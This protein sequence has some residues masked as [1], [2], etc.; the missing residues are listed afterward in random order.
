MSF[1][2]YPHQSGKY[3]TDFI[4][5]NNVVSWDSR[6]FNSCSNN[7]VFISAPTGMGKTYF[8]E[9]TLVRCLMRKNN[10]IN[11]KTKILWIGNRVA[12]TRQGKQRLAEKLCDI[13]G[14]SDFIHK[15][16][17][18]NE[19][20]LDSFH[21]FG[22]V[23]IYSYQ[24]LTHAFTFDKES[25]RKLFQENEFSYIVFDECHYFTS[26]ALF[27]TATDLL[28]LE[29][30]KL[31][32]RSLRIYMSA[33]LEE[34]YNVISSAEFNVMRSLN[35]RIPEEEYYYY[36][37]RNYNHIKNIFAYDNLERL[38]PK[39]KATPKDK[40]LIFV[41]SK[42]DGKN[43]KENL[44]GYSKKDSTKKTSD[45]TDM[46]IVFVTAD[47]KKSSAPKNECNAYIKIIEEEKFEE[48]VLISTAVLDNGINIKDST[49]K[50]IVIDILDRTQFIQMLGRLRGNSNS[51]INLYIR[52]YTDE[53]VEKYLVRDVKDLMIRLNLDRME[54]KEYRQQYY[55][56]LTYPYDERRN[57]IFR[58]IGDSS[59]CDYNHYSIG[60]LIERIGTFIKILNVKNPEYTIDPEKLGNFRDIRAKLYNYYDKQIF[61]SNN[62]YLNKQLCQ[63]LESKSEREYRL[64]KYHEYHELYVNKQD[65]IMYGLR[66]RYKYYESVGLSANYLYTIFGL[67]I[68]E[69][70]KNEQVYCPT[71]K[72]MKQF[73]S[74]EQWRIFENARA[75]GVMPFQVFNL[76]GTLQTFDKYISHNDANLLESV[77]GQIQFI[78]QNILNKPG[79]FVFNDEQQKILKT[80]DENTAKKRKEL[81]DISDSE[82]PSLTEQVHWIERTG[83][84][85]LENFESDSKNLQKQNCS[86]SEIEQVTS[87][88][89]ENIKKDVVDSE[90]NFSEYSD[91]SDYDKIVDLIDRVSIEIETYLKFARDNKENIS[92][93]N[94]ELLE[95]KA[96]PIGN[97]NEDYKKILNWFAQVD[98]EKY[99]LKGLAKKFE[100]RPLKVEKNHYYYTYKLKIV[101]GTTAKNQRI[102][103]L[104]VREK[105]DEKMV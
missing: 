85:F 87:D 52:N 8:V 60:K 58:L 26:D 37:E 91:E 55:E 73:M 66:H 93:S 39:I 7:T 71:L 90:L 99:D 24:Q 95:D 31:S 94:A 4:K 46:S 6:F 57:N 23:V 98:N 38:I 62:F 21:D 47:S 14:N 12:L 68:P 100:K 42:K 1:K 83:F 43:F 75:F 18:L 81:F 56:S 89:K 63:I 51:E 15:I 104:F 30:L 84:S 69:Q 88:V 2:Y 82:Y 22:S 78:Y 103:A 48:R 11:R 32:Y 77:Q 72:N 36:F 40:W 102:Y 97:V 59:F 19:K 53:D 49:V 28:L 74:Y 67:M 25:F 13:T 54:T 64:S 80:I 27:N 5:E 79:K 33:T 65:R 101:R 20:G 35:T 3:L 29:I 10:E 45:T 41:G 34:C 86:N 76:R 92:F 17:M 9:N 44:S 70:L 50:H 16:E 96:S 105:H 61:S